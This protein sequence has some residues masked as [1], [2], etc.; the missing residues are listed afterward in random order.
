MP[1]QILYWLKFSDFGGDTT[2]GGGT[3]RI[4]DC[5]LRYLLAALLLVV[6]LSAGAAVA[7][8]DDVAGTVTQVT[9]NAQIQRGA[10]K[11]TITTGMPVALHDQVSTAAGG[12]L[13][14]KMIDGST[15]TLSESSKL[16][17]DENVVSGGVRS[18][19]TVGLLGGGLRSLVTT[20]A[21]SA[22][23]STFKVQTPNAIA[24][25]RGTDFSTSY[26]DGTARKGFTN[27]LKFTDVT[28]S[29]GK[30]VLANNPPK[31]GVEVAVTPGHKATVACGAAPILTSS[32][33]LGSLTGGVTAETAA[34]GALGAAGIIGG[35]TA[36]VIEGTSGGGG[37][38]AV[39]ASPFR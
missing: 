36:G 23:T 4:G 1:G 25:V 15:L 39:T 38:G 7:R 9:G 34:L 20:V 31:P 13:T 16:T 32:G 2:G 37:G 29:S 27:C 6:E 3:M 33:V 14:L 11:I 19:T 26:S 10:T 22:G 5:R 30:V 18:S 17:I 35:V 12:Q 21:R 8:A 24:G 28:T